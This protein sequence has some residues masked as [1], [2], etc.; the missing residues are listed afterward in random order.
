MSAIGRDSSHWLFLG[1]LAL[2]VLAPLPKGSVA[3]WAWT[4]LVSAL[5]LLGVSWTVQWLR[6]R[7]DITPAFRHAR[8]ALIAL[9]LWCLWIALQLVELPATWVQ[10]ISPNAYEIHALAATALN[11]PQ[12]ANLTLS[13]DPHATLDFLMKSV[14]WSTAFALTLLLVDRRERVELLLKTLVICGTLQAL[15]GSV[16]MLSGLEY[17]FLLKKIHNLGVATGSYVNRNHLAGYLNICLAAGIGLMIARLGGEATHTWR[18]RVRSLARLLLGEKARLR[19]YLIVMVIGLVLT[20]SRMGNTAFF[21]GTLVVGA[22][23]LLLMRNAPRSTMLFLASLVVLDLVIVGTWFGV[24][25]VAQRIKATEVT[26]NVENVM[27]TED[28]D[29]VDR[30]ALPYLKDFWLTGSGG[31]SF[32]VMFPR[33]HNEKLTGFYDFAHNDYV[34]IAAETGAVGLLLCGIVVLGALWQSLLA[35]RRRRDPL[36]RGTAFG[37][38]MGVC[39]LLIHS[40]V[41]FNLQMPATSLTMTVMLALA[42]IASSLRHKSAQETRRSQAPEHPRATPA[43]GQPSSLRP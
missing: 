1:L 8:W 33:Y 23:G 2:L 22:L 3:T 14:A 16:M 24:D 5:C 41:D 38:A 34:Q 27:P 31:G 19:I 42:W 10:L 12:P 39:W 4:I 32:Y 13:L 7:C 6:R 18:Q 9:G 29:E 28:R 30:A 35:M 20:R 26:T 17:G 40:T 36:M 43:Q 21:A 37:V 15:Y 25:Q 11:L